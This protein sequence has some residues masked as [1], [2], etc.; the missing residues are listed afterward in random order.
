M[1]LDAYLPDKTL[2]VIAAENNVAETA[3]IVPDGEGRWQ[4][5]WFTPTVEVPLCGHATLGSAHVVF[6]H[7]GYD[8]EQVTFVTRQSGELF[9][10][11]ADTGL[12]MDFPVSPLKQVEVT[13]EMEAALGTRPLAAWSGNF[14]AC[15][16][17]DT[18]AILNLSPDYAALAKIDGSAPGW[19]LGNVGCVAAGGPSGADVIS[20][21]FA[22]GSGIGEDP[23]T[24]AWHCMVAPLMSAQ[25]DKDKLNC[26]QA[27]PGRGAWIG[28]EVQGE[29]V[30]LSGTSVTVIEGQF[31]V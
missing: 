1:P 2:Q 24:G 13:P 19:D 30:K 29:R 25:L 10:S 23:A 20:R 22:P 3:F 21:F 4:L 15:L 27:Y 9:V 12:I 31:Y 11:R 8:G 16:F 17:A 18:E 14:L 26:F 6:E 28:T 5:R 7:L